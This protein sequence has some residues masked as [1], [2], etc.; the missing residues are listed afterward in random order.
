MVPEITAINNDNTPYT[1]NDPNTEAQI[2][3]N[4]SILSFF[5]S[6]NVSLLILIKI[7]IIKLGS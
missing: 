3:N 7:R 6:G 1:I 5:S 4:F 2:K